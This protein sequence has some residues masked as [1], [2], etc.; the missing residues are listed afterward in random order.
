M[1]KITH[2]YV[3]DKVLDCI[4]SGLVSDKKDIA[5]FMSYGSMADLW[6]GSMSIYP[7]SFGVCN[8]QTGFGEVEIHAV[9][10]MKD[11]DGIVVKNV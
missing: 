8:F 6:S 7:K 10:S 5:V 11:E 3:V 9:A 4:V 2:S 1:S